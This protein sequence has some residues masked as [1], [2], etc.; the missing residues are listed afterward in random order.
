MDANKLSYVGYWTF[1]KINSDLTKLRAKFGLIIKASKTSNSKTSHIC[2]LQC[3]HWW[4]FVR[5][6]IIPKA[7]SGWPA[8]ISRQLTSS[9][10]RPFYFCKAPTTE[11]STLMTN[12]QRQ[13]QT[14]YYLA[15]KYKTKHSLAGLKKG[16]GGEKRRP[17]LVVDPVR[18]AG[19]SSSQ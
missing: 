7:L 18:V 12:Q 16:A 13:R 4:P 2:L 3:N 19:S 8:T 15:W 17:G 1:E 14:Q 11:G 6:I 5:F 10:R 9:G